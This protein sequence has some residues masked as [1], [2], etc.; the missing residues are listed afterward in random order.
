M[1]VVASHKN[2]KNMLLATW[3]NGA[4]LPARPALIGCA[5]VCVLCPGGTQSLPGTVCV[6]G[7]GGT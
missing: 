1:Q 2:D 5:H 6:G 7:P 3:G 4:G